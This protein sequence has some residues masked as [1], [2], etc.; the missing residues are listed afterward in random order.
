M[1]DEELEQEV[2]TQEQ[3]IIAIAKLLADEEA[4]LESTTLSELHSQLKL[5]I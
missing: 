4:K 5:Y 2:K 3:Q 1:P